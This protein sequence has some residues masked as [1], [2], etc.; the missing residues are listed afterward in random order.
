MPGSENRAT[1]DDVY[2]SA[3]R[4]LQVRPVRLDGQF[5]GPTRLMKRLM[6]L[7][8]DFDRLVPGIRGHAV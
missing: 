7:V 2:A 4:A 1:L 3:A 5:D 8:V 6:C